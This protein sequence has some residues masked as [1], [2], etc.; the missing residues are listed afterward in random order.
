MVDTQ[1]TIA[2]PV[3]DEILDHAA[4]SWPMECCGLL[5][6]ARDF[7]A[8]LGANK[9]AGEPSFALRPYEMRISRCVVA[10]N[11]ADDP[12]M[13][14]EIDPSLLLRTHRAVR[15]SGEEIIGCYHSHPNGQVLPSRTDLQR[16]EQTGF[17]WLIAGSVAE[18]VRDWAIYQRMPVTDNDP[19]ARYFQTLDFRVDPDDIAR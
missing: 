1:I 10:A 18:G 15:E 11:V 7:D 6:G 3:L 9:A 4:Q 12:T 19:A 16:A 8:G 2:K 5:I 17:L 14:F 13:T